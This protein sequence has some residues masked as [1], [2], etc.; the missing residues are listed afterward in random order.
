MGARRQEKVAAFAAG[1]EA[2]LGSRLGEA[3][4]KRERDIIAMIGQGFSNKLIARTLQISP[5]TVKSHVKNIF[6]KLSVSTRSEAVCRAGS[7]G[8]L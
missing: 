1:A 6:A 8:L 4:S 5:E 7:L 3:L 2:H